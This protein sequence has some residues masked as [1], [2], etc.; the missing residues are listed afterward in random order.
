LNKVKFKQH[1]FS[2]NDIHDEQCIALDYDNNR[3]NQIID[4]ELIESIYLDGRE[5]INNIEFGTGINVTYGFIPGPENIPNVDKKVK[6]IQEV[7]IHTQNIA[8]DE[9]DDGTIIEAIAVNG[10]AKEKDGFLFIKN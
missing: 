10:S 2:A 1:P 3:N 6:I 9:K 8:F 7:P 4:E 5:K